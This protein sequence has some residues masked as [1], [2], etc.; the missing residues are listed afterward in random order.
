MATQ[1]HTDRPPRSAWTD[2]RLDDL[3]LSVREGFARVDGRF[4]QM[5]SRFNQMEGRFN[6]MEGRF[7]QME[8]RL[9][10][11][12]GRIDGLQR[13]IMVGSLSL[14]T[15]VIATLVTVLLRI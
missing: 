2:E 4:N 13:A 11:L 1:P 12:D 9:G 10:H 7:D 5:E 14:T 15:A 3:S 6:Q 8:G